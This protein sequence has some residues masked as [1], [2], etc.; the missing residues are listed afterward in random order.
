VIAFMWEN[1]PMLRLSYFSTA[2]PS[3]IAERRC[4]GQIINV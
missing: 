4:D 1:Y 3:V 2:N